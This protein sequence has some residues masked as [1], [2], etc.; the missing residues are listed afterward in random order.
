MDKLKNKR[1]LKM[2]CNHVGSFTFKIKDLDEVWKES[3]LDFIEKFSEWRQCTQDGIE[4]DILCKSCGDM[5]VI[6]YHKIGQKGYLCH[7][8]LMKYILT[9]N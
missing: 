6:A 9:C 5:F 3:R 2:H 7:K 1:Y 4:K 8:C